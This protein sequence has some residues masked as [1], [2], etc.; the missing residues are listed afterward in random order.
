MSLHVTY[1]T[2]MYNYVHI[3]VQHTHI[4]V[5]T[6]I[7]LRDGVRRRS[8]VILHRAIPASDPIRALLQDLPDTLEEG[9]VGKNLIITGVHV[10]VF[11]A[12]SA[13]TAVKCR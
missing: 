13:F 8:V 9:Q 6:H 1:V 4:H 5:H 3:H 12:E 2:Y 7:T 10:H 11:I